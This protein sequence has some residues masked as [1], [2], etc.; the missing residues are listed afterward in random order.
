ME[1]FCIILT[2]KFAWTTEP[3][4]IDWNDWAS[5]TLFAYCASLL[6]ELTQE[7]PFYL[8]YGS[9]RKEWCVIDMGDYIEE[10]I[11]HGYCMVHGRAQGQVKKAQQKQQHD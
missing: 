3:G 5:F 6:Q 8:L 1:Q 7:S 4:G 9:L 2:I 10:F 11:T